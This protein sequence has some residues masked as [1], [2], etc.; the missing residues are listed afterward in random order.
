M[1]QDRLNSLRRYARLMRLKE[2]LEESVIVV[3]DDPIHETPI[4]KMEELKFHHLKET[5]RS[6]IIDQLPQ[7]IKHRK[8]RPYHN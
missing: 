6:P 3:V 5:V 2:I 8:K 1:D 7:E 4:L